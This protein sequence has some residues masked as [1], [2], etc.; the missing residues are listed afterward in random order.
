MSTT[1]LGQPLDR[2]DGRRKVTGAAGY[3]ADR[4]PAGVA[5]AAP[6]LSTIAAGEIVRLDPRAAAAAPGVLAVLHHGNSPKL[7]R[8]PDEMSAGLKISEQRPPFEDQK[9]YYAGQIVAVVVAG[10]LEQARWAARLVQVKYH[11]TSPLLTLDAGIAA[12]KSRP[13][14]DEATQRG[15]P[16]KAWRNSAVQIDATY[17]TP[18]EVHSAMELHSAVAHWEGDRLTVDD[19][20]QWVYGQA[21]SLA[22]VLGIP[23]D[24][25][26]VRAAFVGG[27]FGSK[28]FLWPHTILAA[29]AA[30]HL[31]R[32][33][34]F[35]LPRQAHFSTAGHRPFTRQRVRL[36]AESDGRLSAIVH[37]AWTHTSQVTHY[38]ESCTE[39]TPP[40]YSCPHVGTSHH[41]VSLHVGSPTSMRGPGTCPGTFA[42]ETALDELALQLGRD[43]LELR[44]KNIPARDEQRDVPWSANHFADCLRGAADRF[45]W[46]R[47]NPAVGSMRDQGEVLGWGLAAA[48]WPAYR[49]QATVQVELRADNTAHVSCATQD[50]GTGTYTVMAQVVAELTSLPIDRITVN[51]GDSSLPRGPISGGSMVTATVVPAVALATRRA[52]E[53]LGIDRAGEKPPHRAEAIADALRR[54]GRE[55]VTAEATTKPGD[56]TKQFSFRCFGAHCVEVRWD[57]GVSRLRVSRVVSVFD[58][59]RIINLKTATNQLEG[60]IVMGLGMALREEAIYDGRTGRVVNDNLADYHLMVQA[61]MPQLDVTLLD[62]PDPHI[63]EFGAKGLGEI[64]ITGIAAAISNAVHHATGKRI[65]DLPITIEKLLG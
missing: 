6:V 24:R 17:T 13:Q 38:V 9:I 29:V 23:A 30:R 48:T 43:P 47:R 62:R 21:R 42:V 49:S 58:A 5:Y 52:L 45:G 54:L 16:E 2:I 12:G 35:V 61:D 8:C 28:L 64:G 10:T 25:V 4:T 36:G 3:A 37:E 53:E 18:V 32:P 60:G 63:G 41:V 46:A 57:S 50:I 34:S 44:L 14:D 26:V 31:G 19:S 39:S 15:D 20:T 27:G 7:H 1:I 40:L 33:V 65:R 59:G 56:E 11:A 55:S 22:H 51:L